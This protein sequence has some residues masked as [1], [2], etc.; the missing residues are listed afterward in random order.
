M[1]IRLKIETCAFEKIASYPRT[2]ELN[3]TNSKYYHKRTS[4][5]EIRNFQVPRSKMGIF[6]L[7]RMVP[8]YKCFVPHLNDIAFPL[9]ELL[10]NKCTDVSTRENSA[11]D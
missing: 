5:N 7:V 10:G 4:A 6:N 9:T 3:T 2:K 1:G 11:H 8:N